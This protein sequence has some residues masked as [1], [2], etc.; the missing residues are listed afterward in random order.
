MFIFFDDVGGGGGGGAGVSVLDDEEPRR[1]QEDD[2]DETMCTLFVVVVV[3][4]AGL[5]AESRLV[6]LVASSIVSLSLSS[7]SILARLAETRSASWLLI[8]SVVSSRLVAVGW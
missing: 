6:S 7:S 4:F 3:D 5:G 2:E 1:A 8:V